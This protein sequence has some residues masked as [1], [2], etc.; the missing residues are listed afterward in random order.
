MIEA[1]PVAS[2]PPAPVPPP[3]PAAVPANVTVEAAY[4][5]LQAFPKETEDAQRLPA[6]RAALAATVEEKNKTL[7]Q[8]LA[9]V[10]QEKARIAGLLQNQDKHFELQVQKITE[11]VDALWDK[12]DK[13]T[14][15]HQ[16]VTLQ[17]KERLDGLDQLIQCLSL[18][19]DTAPSPMTL[20]TMTPPK[21]ELVEE[22]DEPVVIRMPMMELRPLG[23]DQSFESVPEPVEEAPSNPRKL[24]RS[25]A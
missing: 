18:T 23:E 4:A 16:R 10:L 25:A 14:E 7:Q 15:H 20:T 3:P 11:A 5:M 17:G 13:L 21:V 22:N 1:T 12:R 6:L 9:E 8:L 24:Y 2:P 19:D